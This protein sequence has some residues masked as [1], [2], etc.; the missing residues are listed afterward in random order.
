MDF[1]KEAMDKA[2]CEAAI[3]YEKIPEEAKKMV[4]E[5]TKAF[6]LKAGYK[7]LGRIL[8]GKF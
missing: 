6:Y 7:R 2:A 8:V 1:D 4:E 5:W 3:V